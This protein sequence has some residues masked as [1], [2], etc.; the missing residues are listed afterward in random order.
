MVYDRG[1]KTT[2]QYMNIID[3]PKV[4]LRTFI[5]Q[6]D[7]RRTESWELLQQ[8]KDKLENKF[9]IQ[10]ILDQVWDQFVDNKTREYLNYQQ[11]QLFLRR[12]F[13][14]N[15]QIT[16]Q[17]LNRPIEEIS[18]EDVIKAVKDC[19]TNEDG[20]ISKEELQEWIVPYMKK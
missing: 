20:Y 19:D 4:I 14:M 18:G 13:E 15:E 9:V 12:V 7:Q 1:Q 8:F 2:V 5:S 3:V 6:P 16:A 17:S 10:H 11:A